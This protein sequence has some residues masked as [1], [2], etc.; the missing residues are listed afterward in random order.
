MIQA[1]LN[2]DIYDKELLAIVECFKLWRPYLEGSRHTI[3]IYTDHNSLRYFTTTKQLSWHQAR[4][5]ER[6]QSFDFVINYRPGQLG[7]KPDALTRR[8]DVYPKKSFMNEVNAMN[9]WVVIPPDQLWSTILL[10]DEALFSAIHQAEKDSEW[11]EYSKL[12]DQKIRGFEWRNGLVIQNGRYYVPNTAELR[13]Q[14]LQSRHDHKLRGHPG[15]RKM[16]DLIMR[17]FF[18]PRITHDVKGY[19]GACNLCERAKSNRHKPF[20]QLKSLPI[21]NK[22]WATISMD[23]IVE[24]PE[25]EGYDAVLVVVCRFS[26][27]AIFIPT[28]KTDSAHDLAQQFITHVFSKHGLPLDIISDRGTTFVSQFWKELCNSL[29]VRTK[30]STAY[31][32]ET[33]GQTERVNQSLEQY[34]CVYINYMQDNWWELLSLAE[35]V[36][37]NTVHSSHGLTPFF[38]NKGFHPT[39]TVD[40]SQVKEG[41]MHTVASDI[42]D[43]HAYC[44]RELQKAAAYHAQWADL[45]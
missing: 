24:L 3:Q 44:K 38:V 13:L 15:V 11:T 1:E 28:H 35:F 30:L 43:V 21:A 17:D 2:Y 32:P 42:Q 6:L 29:G 33:D 12:A 4:W 26:K 40:M 23:H 34:L 27:Q 5:S 14:V 41:D 7:E 25:S 45:K 31:H 10:N 16:K 20:G 36:Y 8:A 22:P 37:N 18:W 19:V 9:Q 39:L